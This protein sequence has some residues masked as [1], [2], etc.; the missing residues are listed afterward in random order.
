[1]IEKFNLKETFV[2]IIAPKRHYIEIAKGAIIH[3]RRLLERY[4]EGDP[5]FKYT[6]EPYYPLSNTERPEIVKR[7]IDAGDAVGIGPMAAVAGVI[8]ELAVEAVMSEGGTH[9]IID[10]GGDIAMINEE[11]TIIGIY[12]T[13]D[14]A[15]KIEPR[16]SMLGICT[17]SAK[18]GHSIS[19]GNADAA[20]VISRSPS[21]ADAAATAL[22]NVVKDEDLE[23]PFARIK[24]VKLVDGAIVIHGDTVAMWGD[25]PKIVRAKVP[26]LY[27]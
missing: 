22:G 9:V 13:R 24:D 2:T 20:T 25:L 11:P 5:I 8:A 12:P 26:R 17:S 4:I 15:L 21:L 23:E 1:M 10:N 18:I 27:S 7:M 6:I 3:H 16:D 14:L 19:F